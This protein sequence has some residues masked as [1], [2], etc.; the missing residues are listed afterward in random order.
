MSEQKRAK[1]LVVDD[2]VDGLRSLVDLFAHQYEVI[3]ASSGGE[4]IEMAHK[5]PDLATIVLDIKMAG[6]DGI[7]AARAIRSILPDTPIIL[8][9]AFP[10]EYKE[11][12]IDASEKPYDFVLKGKTVP[13]L[14]RSVRN[15][16]ENYELKHDVRR[17]IAIA[18][19]QYQLY[20]KSKVMQKVYRMIH[21]AAASDGK[22][23]ILGESGTG[24]DRVARAI[25]A[26]SIRSEKRWAIL[27]CN[28]Q[29]PELVAAELFGALKGSYTG[30]DR[31]RIGLFEFAQGG[32]VFLDEVG[33]LDAHT[34]GRLLQVIDTGEYARLGSPE[35]RRADVRIICATH[36]NL[37]EL[38]KQERF[39]HDL[40]H[41]LEGVRI[42]LPPLRERRED[43]PFL[44]DG[45][46]AQFTT[47]HGLPPKVFDPAAINALVEQDWSSGNVRELLEC[48]ESLIRTCESDIIFEDDVAAY[49]GRPKHGLASQPR[50]LSERLKDLERTLIIGALA[51]SGGNVTAASKLLEIDRTV[52]HKKIKARDIDVG[53]LREGLDSERV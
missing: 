11:N 20:G 48:V 14:V 33:D 22:V 50:G 10:G 23:M 44:V 39:R 29:A 26:F 53:C 6:M 9:T 15:G 37:E 31:D 17:L 18:E 40:Y 3:A 45:F 36:R 1:I 28:N 27:A 51:E 30:C 19:K 46:T 4:A 2:D 47:D 49:L 32:T 12:D 21:Q 7:A 41:R 25:H 8:H 16:V 35:V 34:Q 52:L 43:I 24:K 5:H 13:R 42:I 38:V